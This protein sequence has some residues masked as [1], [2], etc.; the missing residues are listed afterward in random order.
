MEKIFLLSHDVYIYRG[1]VILTFN[2]G[3]KRGPKPPRK[4]MKYN[5]LE[6]HFI[7]SVIVLLLFRAS[8]LRLVNGAIGEKHSPVAEVIALCL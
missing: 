7:S 6:W 5:Q 4:T 8:S 2:I 1:V 3:K